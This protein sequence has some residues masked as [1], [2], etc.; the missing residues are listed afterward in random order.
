MRTAIRPVAHADGPQRLASLA[1]VRYHSQ[2]MRFVMDAGRRTFVLLALI[3]ILTIDTGTKTLAPAGQAAAFKTQVDLVR[4]DVLATHG[5]RPIAGLT[6]DDFEVWD[7]GVRQKAH[8]LA[9]TGSLNIVLVLDR[10]GSLWGD[11]L[12]RLV[13][14]ASRVLESLAPGDQVTLVHAAQAVLVSSSAS[15]PGIAL[16]AVVSEGHQGGATPLHDAVFVALGLGTKA[17]GRFLLIVMSDGLE[18]ASWLTAEEVLTAARQ[19]ECVAYCLTPPERLPERRLGTSPFLSRLA[20]ATGGEVIRVDNPFSVAGELEGVLKE[21]R[22]RYLLAFTPTGVRSD[23][24]W[25]ELKVRLKG[26]PGKV[27]ARPGYF[28]GTRTRQ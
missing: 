8:I 20:H 5:D 3:T 13:E 26:R 11:Q 14:A 17:F 16:R 6:A 2:A 25:H 21:F 9:A 22:S 7:Q 15:E 28:A 24:G 10:S 1:A 19:E 18:N 4:L 12:Q 27:K 23:D